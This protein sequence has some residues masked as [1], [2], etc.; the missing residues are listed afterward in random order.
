MLNHFKPTLDLRQEFLLRYWQSL[1][2]LTR[3]AVTARAW[4]ALFYTHRRLMAMA[5]LV[6]VLIGVIPFIV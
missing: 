3:L 5:F 2:G 1:L 6:G 4:L